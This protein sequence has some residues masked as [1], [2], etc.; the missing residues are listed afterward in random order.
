ME[1]FPAGSLKFRLMKKDKDAEF[2][3]EHG[4][5]ILRQAATALAFM[6][7]KGWVHRDVKPDNLLV[8]ASGSVRLIDFAIAKRITKPSFFSS[9]VPQARESTGTRSAFFLFLAEQIRG[10]PLDGRADIYSFALHVLRNGER[11]GR[12]FRGATSQDMLSKAHLEKPV[13][14]DGTESRS[15]QGIRRTRLADARQE[16]GRSAP[17]TSTKC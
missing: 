6:N 4:Q 2:L 14:P 7:A 11:A 5:D 1:F 3:R 15:N 9:L 8:N 12:R 16:E 13:S 17:R 10:E